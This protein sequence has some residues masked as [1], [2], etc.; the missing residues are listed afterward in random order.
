MNKKVFIL[1]FFGLLL[2]ACSAGLVE[3]SQ[4]R[5]PNR[6]GIFYES[7]LLDS[8]PANG[9][10]LLWS[11]E[12]LGAGH[13]SVGIG[14]ETVYVNGMP[15]TMGILYAFDF[16]G[17][18]RWKKTY[19]EEWH[20]NY[21]GSR[22]TPVVVNDKVYL[23]SGMGV[24]YCFDAKSGD[25]VWQLNVIEK[26][27]GINIR[28][29][30]TETLLIHNEKIYCAP[31]GVDNNIV[32]LNRFTGETIWT[33]KGFSEPSA[34]CSPVLADHNGTKLLLTMTT[35]SA[36]GLDA[37]TGEMYWRIEQNQ[38]NKIHANS[39]VY[40]D[41]IVYFSS[42]SAKTNGGLLA[43]KLSENGKK[44]SQL[45]R[46]ESFKNLMGGIVIVNQTIYG[47][48][49][50]SK[51]WYAIDPI[52]GNATLLTDNFTNGTIIYADNHFYCYNEKG[53]MALVDIT[54]NNFDI[55]G[56]FSVPLG[57]KEHWS[58]PVIHNKRLYLRHGNALMV[59]DISKKE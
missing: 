32:A 48:K 18:L 15:D 45:W 58:H 19:G 49:Y 10:E 59:Y 47:S 1:Q 12:G 21:T 57:T 33:S 9:P 40:K 16:E 35:T 13:S 23:L 41:G 4:W 39:P 54:N 43:L 37:E 44:V 20:I 46:N 34:Y 26:F 2:I 6:Q 29:G 3:N 17:I 51:E 36:L 14:N 53:E 28:W 11:F 30:I 50:R 25:I 56:K 52:H 27:N 31:G 42:S 22:S 5:G 24:I 7:G 38:G 8:W 55:L